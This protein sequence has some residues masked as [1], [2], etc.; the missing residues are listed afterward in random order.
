MFR[1]PA[2]VALGCVVLALYAAVR[3]AAGQQTGQTVAELTARLASEEEGVR[4]QAFDALVALGEEGVRGLLEL[5]A[6]PG[7]ANAAGVKFGLHGLAV[8]V[9]RPGAEGERRAFVSALCEYLSSKAP[10]E[11]KRFVIRQ[12]QIAGREDAVPAL[13]ALLADEQLGETARQALIANRT[14]EALRALR[15]AVAR[16]SGAR[17]AAIILALGERRDAAAV[18]LLLQQAKSADEQVRLAAIEALGRIGDERAAPVI[19]AA[20]GQGP[21]RV[22]E[23]ALSAYLMLGES[24]VAAGKKAQA[25][26]LYSKALQAATAAHQRCAAIVGLGRTGAPEVAKVV[27][28]YVADADASVRYVAERLLASLPGPEAVRAI[29][30][31]MPGQKPAVRAGLLRVLAQRSEPEAKQA[32]EQAAT[33]PDP[34]VKV[35]ACYLLDRLDDPALEG[36]LLEAAT[37]GS[38]IIHPVALQAYLNLAAARAKKNKK[39]AARAMY[40]NAL[41]AARTDVLRGAALDGL[42]AVA[43][44]DVLPRVKELLANESLRPHALRAY[45]A[46][47]GAVAAAGEKQRAIAMLQEAIAAGPP[48]D[49]LQAAVDSLRKLGVQIDPAQASGYV[50]LW[51][52]LGP[53]A[54]TD[55]NKPYPPERG[56]D[57]AA[58]VDVE[59]KQLRWVKHR[60]SDAQGIVN[61]GA[62]FKPY[63]KQT[64]YLYAE[65]TVDRAQDVVLRIGTDDAVKC[66]LNGRLVHTYASP[67][68]LQ[69]DQDKVPV[70]LRAGKNTI[71]LKVNNFGGEWQACLRITDSQGKPVKF[72]QGK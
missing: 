67:R 71:L 21:G 9:S 2:V 43:S 15:A 53:I 55:L 7:Q 37:R 42:A 65:I 23:A 18:P 19:A 5:L 48:R 26:A 4:K 24:L 32:I 52:A 11:A 62:L 30:Q 51:W 69:V 38:D 34:E 45:V 27:V 41:D 59:G 35:T 56:V 46:V 33:D 20:L 50:T 13:A 58:A 57:V 17:R 14:V 54:G 68:P 47:A 36:A 66:W 16:T 31:A 10:A 3:P 29:A 70:R 44:A 39:Q 25:L 12:L 8:Y 63:S 64:A 60:E 61:L 49:V 72:A 40:L 28:P 22:Q 1:W 6:N